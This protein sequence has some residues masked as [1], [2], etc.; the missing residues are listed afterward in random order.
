VLTVQVGGHPADHPAQGTHQ[1]SRSPLGD[2][3]RQTQVSAG[4]SDLGAGESA[5]DDQYPAGPV[6]QPPTQADGV[7]PAA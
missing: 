4:R 6:G 1:G 3:D 2:R 5:A 7:I